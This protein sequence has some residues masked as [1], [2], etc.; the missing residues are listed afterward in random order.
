GEAYNWLR[1]RYEYW[2][3]YWENNPGWEAPGMLWL[4]KEDYNNLKIFGKR[5][6]KI[7]SRKTIIEQEI[8]E[9]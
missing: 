2:I 3:S 8:S 5:D 4:L 7:R 9:T 6:A 1:R